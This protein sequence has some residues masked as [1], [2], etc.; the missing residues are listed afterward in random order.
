M[1]QP[2]CYVCILCNQPILHVFSA[3]VCLRLHGVLLK[4]MGGIKP[5]LMFAALCLCCRT[6]TVTV[7]WF[8][9]CL[10]IL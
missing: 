2:Q 4:H 10:D 5:L 6:F 1:L 3:S 9:T 8:R 7:T